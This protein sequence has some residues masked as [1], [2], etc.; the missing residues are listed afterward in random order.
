MTRGPET[1][2]PYLAVSDTKCSIFAKPAFVHQVD[3]QLQ[4]V[5]ALEISDFRLVAGVGQRLESGSDQLGGA[6]AKH[7]LLA[8]QIGLGLFAE[9]R[10]DRSGARLRRCRTR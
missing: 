10:L 8:E 9:T 7:G 4:L 3:D 5:Q 6:A 2:S 1:K